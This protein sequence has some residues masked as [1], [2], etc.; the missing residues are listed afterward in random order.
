MKANNLE[1]N[2]D[3]YEVSYSLD[4]QTREFFD[5]I[6]EALDM[7]NFEIVRTNREKEYSNTFDIII[8]DYNEEIGIYK[9]RYAT[10]YYGSTNPFRQQLYLKIENEEL[11][12]ESFGILDYIEDCLDLKFSTNSEI[13]LAVDTDFDIIS[14]FYRLLKNE[15]YT[16]RILKKYYYDMDEE[17]SNVL[18]C[19]KGTRKNPFKFKSFYIKNKESGLELKCYNKSKEIIDNDNKKQYIKDK[20]GF[21]NIYRIEIHVKHKLLKDTMDKMNITDMDIR[22]NLFNKDFLSNLYIELLD[23]LIM[24]RY[25][26]NNYN[27]LSILLN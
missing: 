5:N 9:K 4:Q 13:E 19:S 12:K 16:P 21:D 10:I 22:Y 23:R 18:N 6:D 17:L 25:K 15:K 14:R 7:Y 24:I 2:I 27:F 3:K 1:L 20:L 8:P 26:E 11:Y